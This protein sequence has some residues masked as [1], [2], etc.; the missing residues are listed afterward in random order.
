[1]PRADIAKTLLQIGPFL[2]TTLRSGERSPGITGLWQKSLGLWS[3]F[4]ILLNQG[5]S[6][7][8]S[9]RGRVD[10]AWLFSANAEGAGHVIF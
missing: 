6:G 10:P 1:M 9:P 4:T 5:Q 3:L 7:L 2:A 8:C